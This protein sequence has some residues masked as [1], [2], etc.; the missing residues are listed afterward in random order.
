MFFLAVGVPGDNG[1]GVARVFRD[2]LRLPDRLREPRAGV[3]QG[4]LP[5]LLA[6]F[7][8]R[9]HHL[10]CVHDRRNRLRKVRKHD[11]NCISYIHTYP[12]LKYAFCRTRS[13]L[14]LR[15]VNF[16]FEG[17]T[18]YVARLSTSLGL[19]IIRS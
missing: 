8:E 7:Q 11:P 6:S 3:V 14:V 10:L 17:I 13:S 12:Q 19:P 9:G 5:L 15:E 18:P 1:L 2:R 4:A 16:S